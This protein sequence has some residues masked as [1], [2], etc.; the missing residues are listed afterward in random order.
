MATEYTFKEQVWHY[1]KR[2]LRTIVPQLPAVYGVVTGSFPNTL[3]YLMLTGGI[4]TC[5]D[6]FCRNKGYY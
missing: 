4:L 1:S 3:P 6:K 5:M 2:F